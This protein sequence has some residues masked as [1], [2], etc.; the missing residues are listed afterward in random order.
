MTAIVVILV[1]LVALGIY[2]NTLP[3][4][5]D[6]PDQ[7]APAPV[8]L[9]SPKKSSDTWTVLPWLTVFAVILVGALLSQKDG[10]GVH[11]KHERVASKTM[12]ASPARSERPA[13]SRPL[14]PPQSRERVPEVPASSIDRTMLLP[15]MGPVVRPMTDAEALELSRSLGMDSSQLYQDLHTTEPT[16]PPTRSRGAKNGVPSA[17]KLPPL[18]HNGDVRV[19]AYTRKDGTR[20]RAHTRKS[21]SR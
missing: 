20:V 3:S 10:R 7:A 19:R 13:S 21:P 1:V 11:N 2:G 14:V 16:P 18:I 5:N 8:P 4:E 12:P 17:G 6:A 9:T 15:S